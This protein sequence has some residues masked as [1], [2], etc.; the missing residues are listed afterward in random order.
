MKC[1]SE[2]R[3]ILDLKPAPYNPRKWSDKETADLTKSIERFDLAD[4]I[5]INKNNTVVG[6]H[7]R[8]KILKEKGVTE[9]DVRVPERELTEAEEK[10]LNIRL[11]KNSGS[12]DFDLLS[13]FDEDFLKDIG[14]DSKE[15]DK[16]FQ[17][18]ATPEDDDI[19]EVK[20][21]DIKLGDIFQLGEHRLLCGDSTKQEDAEKLMSGQR[22]DMAFTDPPYNVN[23]GATMKDT[24]RGNDR[25]ILNDKMSAEDFDKFLLAFIQNILLYT[26]GGIYICMSSSEMG[27]LQDAFK[28][29]GGHWSTFIIW[30]KN[31]F[32]MGRADYQRQYEPILY[33]WRDGAKHYWCGDRG[34]G[35][36]WNFNKPSVS[37]LHPTM[38]PVDLC[39]KAIENSCPRDGVVLDLFGGSGSTLIAAQLV[40]R[41]CRMMELDPK[42]CQ[43]SN[44][45][46]NPNKTAQIQLN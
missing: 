28:K 26:D 5:I 30:A 25:T 37:K 20:T 1:L 15:L 29:A 7:F 17:L 46:N 27:S 8:L 16:I 21:T 10:E 33:G 11:N 9:V 24:L 34:Q 32:T 31:T 2:K 22:A 40:H 18:E 3:N 19:P 36:V 13:N 44:C 39:I 42:Y 23:Y 14:F 38:K 41:K 45:Y 35:D 4:H 6:G 43:D 12:F